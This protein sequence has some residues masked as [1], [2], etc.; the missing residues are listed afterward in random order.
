MPQYQARKDCAFW[1][2]LG[3]Q[4]SSGLIAEKRKLFFSFLSFEPQP[5]GGLLA[6]LWTFSSLVLV[7]QQ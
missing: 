7:S 1:H 4:P 3:S 6:A 5:E 2:W